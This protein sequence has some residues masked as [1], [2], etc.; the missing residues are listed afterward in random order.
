MKI[1]ISSIPFFN[2]PLDKTIIHIKDLGF[3]YLEVMC[4]SPYAHPDDFD[5]DR[6]KNIKKIAAEQK[7]KLL[8][9]APIADINF[10]SLNE[11]IREE[12][13]RQ[14][15]KTIKLAQDWDS[16]R[17][18]FHIGGKP[19]MGLWDEEKGFEYCLG[20]L[21]PVIAEAEKAGVRLLLENDPNKVGLG[22]IEWASLERILQAYEGRL[23]FL[24]DLGHA[25]ML[26]DDKF[27]EFIIKSKDVIEGVHIS[28]NN[29]IRDEHLGLGEG[30]LDVRKAI[31]KLKQ[32]GFNEEIII[33]VKYEKDILPSKLILEQY[34]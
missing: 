27:D 14:L 28:S 13:Q 32:I 2:E 10:M 8:L 22:G 12:A 31:T 9:H 18:V 4:E 20:A 17:V 15:I 3:D 16:S 11:G 34:I 1:G 19:Y 29:R 23:G 21:E 5:E 30:K 26:G 24:L 7:V 33:E 6:R 25:L